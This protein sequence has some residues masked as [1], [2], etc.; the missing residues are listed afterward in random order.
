MAL[1]P[2]LVSELRAT[3]ESLDV[4]DVKME[5]GS[6]RCDANVSLM[7][8]GAKEFGTRTETKSVN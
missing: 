1:P 6:L 3:L 8:K 5:Q 4:S 7:A 2:A